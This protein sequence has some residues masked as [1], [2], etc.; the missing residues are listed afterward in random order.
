MELS[1]YFITSASF[2][3]LFVLIILRV[4]IGVAMGLV[5][6]AGFGMLTSQ[7][8][9]LNLLALSPMRTSTEY[10]L[11]LIPM[12]IL[13]GSF[14]SASGISADL[15][16][17]SQAWLGH[18][19]G[20]LALATI[21]ACSGFAAICGSSVATAATMTKVALPEMRRYGYSDKIASGTIA[22]G[23]SLGI[24]IPPS[25]ILAVYGVMTRQDIGKLFL[26]GVIPGAL[27]IL[28]YCLVIIIYS[29]LYPDRFPNTEVTSWRDRLYSMIGVLPTLALFTFVI[30]G[31][32]AGMFTPSEGAGMGAFGTFLIGKCMGRLP[33]SKV[34][35]CLIDS[36]RVSAAIFLVLIGAL[37]FGYFLTVSRV[38]QHMTE[39][40]IGLE[41]GSYGTLAVILIAL[42]LLG[43]ILDA[44][45]MI[46]LVVPIIFPVILQL[47]F[48]PIWFGVIMVVAVELALI[49]PPIGMNV[50]VINGVAKDISLP[51]IFRGVMPFV[52]IDIVRLILLVAFP[53]IVLLLPSW[54]G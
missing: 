52:L 44:M 37:L 18:F 36:I 4:P 51:T 40:L 26:A 16:K 2:V 7:D 8:A 13:M 22:A 20:G 42:F 5:G 43:C 47:G 45:A 27:A 6:V 15:Y 30:G 35:E 48:D 38:P 3:V 9:A 11:G 50:F 19:R 17:S 39:F 33:W 25:I 31:L 28:L 41:L 54:M 23:G 32:Y 21:A 1:P 12:F 10:T 53:A 29:R 14:A 49:T 24:L 46:V 34:L